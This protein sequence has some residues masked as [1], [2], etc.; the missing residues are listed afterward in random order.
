[1]ISMSQKNSESL[2]DDLLTESEI[3]KI[4][5]RVQILDCLLKEMPQR[6]VA[7]KTKSGIAT[8]TRG[9]HLLKKTDLVIDKII[10]QSS[11]MAWWSKLF[12]GK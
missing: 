11:Q 4:Y 7:E 6:A 9:S 12:W 10:D 2:L 1:M 3:D 8:V 5:E